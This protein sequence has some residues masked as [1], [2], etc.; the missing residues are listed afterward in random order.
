MVLTLRTP[1]PVGVIWGRRL[2]MRLGTQALSS[3]GQRCGTL[4]QDQAARDW[5]STETH[6]VAGTGEIPTK[7]HPVR[8]W[9][10]LSFKSSFELLD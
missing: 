4:A 1:G 9:I 5:G 2:N 8:G 3:V 7:A 6:S 10:Q